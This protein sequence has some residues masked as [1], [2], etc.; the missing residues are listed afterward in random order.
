MEKSYMNLIDSIKAKDKSNLNTERPLF[1]TDVIAKDENGKLLFRKHNMVV[2]P[3][4]VNILYLLNKK[5]D[6][7]L[8]D[9]VCD[10]N[11]NPIPGYDNPVN[12]ANYAGSE[13]VLFFF[14]VGN[15][16]HIGT[17]AINGDITAPT[18][19]SCV[20]PD[21][22]SH[23]LFHMIPFRTDISQETD[24]H[25]YYCKVNSA[26]SA[27]YY[28]KAV[29]KVELKAHKNDVEISN[30]TD[31]FNI[32]NNDS[33]QVTDVISTFLE[34]RFTISELDCRTSTT[35]E[36]FINELGLFIG[37]PHKT[38]YESINNGQLGN[39][40]MDNDLCQ[41]RNVNMFSHLTFNAEALDGS[42]VIEIT[43]R[44]YA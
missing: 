29:N 26:E 33:T 22:D 16:G 3:G 28:L 1:H 12:G 14:G 7:S 11:L 10:D 35:T 36:N 5:V 6:K 38:V 17:E 8:Y 2:L 21:T 27:G 39:I 15:G 41:L 20:A 42:K 13:P 4:R 31:E 24:K 23:S 43:Y 37:T 40:A 32:A 19:G 34:L 30:N 9:T 44:I 18:V 25:L